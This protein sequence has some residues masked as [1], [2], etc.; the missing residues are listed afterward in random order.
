MVL[1][2]PEHFAEESQESKKLLGDST[3]HAWL[4]VLSGHAGVACLGHAKQ[5]LLK[6]IVHTPEYAMGKFEQ[7]IL[8]GFGRTDA[9]F[10]RLCEEHKALGLRG[11]HSGCC[12]VAAFVIGNQLIVSNLGDSRAVLFRHRRP[13]EML[14][15]HLPTF[16][17]EQTRIRKAGGS[18]LFG[19]VN[20][21]LASS[22]S[23]GDYD[24]KQCQSLCQSPMV[25]PEPD[26]RQMKLDVACRFLILASKGFW[27]VVSMEEACNQVDLVLD[28]KA[29]APKKEEVEEACTQLRDMAAERQPADNVTVAI[30]T[31]HFHDPRRRTVITTFAQ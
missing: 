22:R 23:L 12:V 29:E 5:V 28:E 19:R 16:E 31:F 9:D 10:L 30:L 24:Y 20:G 17:K 21:V 3:P 2:I 25:L 6:S 11:Y 1:N 18:V 4:A 13:L 27:N 14:G 26:V 8:K 7:A 15:E